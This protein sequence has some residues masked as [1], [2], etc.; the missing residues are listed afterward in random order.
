MK[1]TALTTGLYA[2][3]LLGSTGAYAQETGF[4]W[5]GSIEIGIDS[6]VDADDSA[7]ELTDTYVSIEVAFEAAF[8]DRFGAF[9]TL[10]LESVTDA[11]D[12]RAFEDLGIYVG[13]LGL[14][15]AFG[16]TVVKAGKIS[17]TFAVAWD[18]APGFY[19]TTLAEDYEL[20][21]AIGV[22]VDTPVGAGGGVLSFAAFYA[23]DTFL[24][25]SVGTR[26]GRN[27][28]DDGG[29][30]NTGQLNNFA[31]QYTQEFGDTTAWVGAR[32]LSAGEGDLKD[33]T[34]FVTGL[35]HDFGNGFNMIGELAFF[36]GAGGTDEDATYVTLGGAYSVDDWTFSAATT[37]IDVEGGTDSMI[38]LGVDRAINDALEVNFGLARFDV[39]GEKSTALGIAAVYSF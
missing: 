28:A 4:A 19:G 1:K 29:V 20:S 30:G 22:S 16:D 9:G 37:L 27:S 23:D 39:G 13:E 34:G 5:E 32:I 25:D 15:Y 26:R 6:T 38:A 12:D 2:V 21:E 17:P 31:L 10:S 11:E 8:T 7:A 33:E 35:T 14:S 18:E 36:D 3:A 24:S